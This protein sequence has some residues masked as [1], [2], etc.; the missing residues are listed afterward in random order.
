MNIR[1]A[2]IRD[3]DFFKFGL[4]EVRTIEKRPENDIPVTDE[5]VN[6]LISGITGGTIRVIDDDRGDPAAFVYYRTDFP[7]P[8]VS[9]KIFWIDI[10]F[11]REDMRGSGLGKALYRDMERIAFDLGY[12][13]I[14]IDIFESNT[15]SK[16]FHDNLGFVTVS[17]IYSKEIRS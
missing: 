2:T 14:V 4:R 16:K 11:V 8:Y 5:D 15:R 3:L 17:A 1:N 7:I 6:N 10:M 13:R 12:P 9:G